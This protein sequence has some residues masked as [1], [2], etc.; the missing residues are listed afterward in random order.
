MAGMLSRFHRQWGVVITAMILTACGGGGETSVPSG[1]S[2]STTAPATPTDPVAPVTPPST[3]PGPSPQPPS[4]PTVLLTDADGNGIDDDVDA[5]I[6]ADYTGQQRTNAEL[7]AK[8]FFSLVERTVANAPS[9]AAEL[10][11]VWRAS[12][13]H[14]VGA[15]DATPLLLTWVR[16]PQRLAAYVRALHTLAGWYELRSDPLAECGLKTVTASQAKPLQDVPEP[17]QVCQVQFNLPTLLYVNGVFTSEQTA[18]RQ[19]SELQRSASILVASTK[20]GLYYL[21]PA[22]YY[23]HIPNNFLLDISEVY[24]QKA[25]EIRPALSHQEAYGYLFEPV[26][27]PADLAD[28]V[29]NTLRD[30]LLSTHSTQQDYGVRIHEERLFFK[31]LELAPQRLLI[32]AHSQGNLFAN[33]VVKSLLVPDELGSAD[34]RITYFAVASPANT[35]QYATPRH[36]GMNELR[37]L[38]ELEKKIAAKRQYITSSSDHII[39]KLLRAYAATQRFLP[40]LAA[41]DRLATNGERDELVVSGDITGHGFLETYLKAPAFLRRFAIALRFSA[42]YSLPEQLANATVSVQSTVARTDVAAA[43]RLRHRVDG[44][45]VHL[46]KLPTARERLLGEAFFIDGTELTGV[47]ETE[48]ATHFVITQTYAC[49]AAV[50]RFKQAV[51]GTYRL[52]T[53]WWSPSSD[54]GLLPHTPYFAT[55]WG[56]RYNPPLYETGPAGWFPHFVASAWAMNEALGGVQLQPFQYTDIAWLATLPAAPP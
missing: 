44:I 27:M 24:V 19:A 51:A 7:Y 50:A 6:R 48:T 13:C 12:E 56:A 32:V 42:E 54:D 14:A 31:L 33:P 18:L 11:G 45:R 1:S 8:A 5:R 28:L 34:T 29:E 30:D 39:D 55:G 21:P 43:E 46:K 3:Q 35:V 41:N 52:L 20:A 40:P 49:G 17:P 9:S 25:R 47:E 36:P 23:L 2:P 4:P 26:R 16:S 22:P 53:G 10:L 15:G 38:S 37:D